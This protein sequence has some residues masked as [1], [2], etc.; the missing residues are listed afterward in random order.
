[1]QL[2]E[3]NKSELDDFL[4]RQKHSQFLQSFYWGEF[5]KKAGF[6]VLRYG[7]E[8]DK[9]IVAVASLIKKKLFG[10]FNYFYAPGGPVFGVEVID[11]KIEDIFNFLFSEIEKITKKERCVFLRLESQYLISDS[12]FLLQKTIDLQPAKTLILDLKRTEDELMS[13]MHQ[14]TR[15]NIRLA[16][17]KGV[18][19][20]E[21]GVE[22]FE[23]FW[24][25]MKETNTRDGF[26]LHDKDYYRKM[27]DERG[28]SSL[29][30]KMYLAKYEGKILSA[31]I[32]SF[33]GDTVTYL[34]GASSNEN[35][36]VM[37]PYLLQWE[38]IKDAKNKNYRYYDFF[39]IDEE[40]WP[41]VTRYKKGF[42]EKNINNCL[43]SYPGTYDLVFD[44]MWYNVYK[45]LR[46]IRRKI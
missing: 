10:G 5:Q 7:I 45:V 31:N 43:F 24:K 20:I 32:L 23:E 37:A 44:Q 34:H 33:F 2:I 12:R 15:Y 36:S 39:G 40:K 46:K 30:I 16:I 17:K 18:S 41:G 42:C 19:V 21:G 4:K 25:L 38:V 27:L 26:R 8:I 1:M 14:K 29:V 9:K 28:G 11:L 13:D 35:R 6:N 22:E 3:L